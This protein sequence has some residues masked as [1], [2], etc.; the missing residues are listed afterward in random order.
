MGYSTP[1]MYLTA[2]LALRAAA[3]AFATPAVIAQST[4]GAT[5]LALD[6]RGSASTHIVKVA[7]VSLTTDATNGLTLSITSGSLVRPG[8]TPVTFQVALVDDN[9]A[10][11]TASAFTAASGVP[12]VF[13]TS[14]VT[15]IAK[16]LYIKYTPA[17]L[18][19]PGGYAA[20]IDID[21]GDN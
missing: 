12:Y 14:T 19:D 3:P 9:A 13:A 17:A 4:A 1:S 8:G 6:G 21:V 10:P 16:D 5:N 15:A 7:D 20:S 11:P 18:Q 2:A